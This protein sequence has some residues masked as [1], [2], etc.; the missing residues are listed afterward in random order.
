MTY[1]PANLLR[2]FLAAGGDRKNNS[3]VKD[4]RQF[5]LLKWYLFTMIRK[6]LDPLRSLTA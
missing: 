6:L 1:E 2:Q 3:I 5:A 4:E